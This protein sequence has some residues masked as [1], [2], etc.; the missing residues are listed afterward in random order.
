MGYAISLPRGDT[1]VGEFAMTFADP[2]D[3]LENYHA[4]W[5]CKRDE[6]DVDER[7]I[8]QKTLANGLLSIK[9]GD[10]KKLILHIPSSETGSLTIG[11]EYVWDLQ[12]KHKTTGYITTPLD[13]TLKVNKDI[14]KAI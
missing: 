14:T 12:L 9:T 6:E 13:G 7:A 4:W 5:T 1:Y 10:S 11:V 2:A 3:T 8:F